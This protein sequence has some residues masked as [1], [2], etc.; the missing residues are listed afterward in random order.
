[1]NRCVKG[2][3]AVGTESYLDKREISNETVAVDSI[4]TKEK[5]AAFF[6]LNPILRNIIMTA[7]AAEQFR[8]ISLD[9]GTAVGSA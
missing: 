3:L 8:A 5:S 6:F 7:T 4:K 9:P 1:M 2:V